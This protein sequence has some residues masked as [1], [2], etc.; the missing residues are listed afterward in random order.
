LRNQVALFV[1][2]LAFVLP[3]P[4]FQVLAQGQQASGKE[5]GKARQQKAIPK[6]PEDVHRSQP[7]APA[8]AMEARKKFVSD[9]VNAAVDLA[10]GDPQD[11]LRVLAAAANVMSSVS[12]E[13]AREFADEGVQLEIR[14]VASGKKPAV[15]IM[16]R[17]QMKCS[18]AQDFVEMLPVASVAAA[19][20]S[21]LGALS[22]CRRE[23]LEPVKRKLKDAMQSGVLAPRALLAAME[24]EGLKSPWSTEQFPALFQSL[25]R[26]AEKV[27]KEAPNFAA[28][29]ARVAPEIDATVAGEAGLHLLEW[30]GR[31]QQ[32]DER[33]LAVNITTGTLQNILGEEKYKELLG[34]NVMALQVAQT[35][36]Q[37]GEIGHEDEENVSVLKALD[38][39]GSDQSEILRE[40]P[41]SLRARE[42][43]AHGFAS[44]TGGDPEGAKK[45][46]DMAFS[47][48]NEVW[49]Q[50]EKQ[51]TAAEVVQEVSEA[52]A[53]VDTVAALRRVQGLSDPSAQ[54]IG[55]LAV[56]RVALS[57]QIDAPPPPQAREHHSGQQ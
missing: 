1:C 35:A 11:R 48:L 37:P 40:L 22:T 42:A 34:K 54:A 4:A 25:P 24:A 44:G 47:A 41:P 6:N 16:E 23:T 14:L 49:E 21:I 46:F 19:E 53:H 36:G 52:A 38:A 3:F 39:N 10:Q 28:M 55:M 20:Q 57:R 15:S 8:S 18:V 30:L 7:P 29:F 9:V 33:N 43:A 31:L 2:L 27:S 13:K 50:R 45:Y 17:G 51:N 56:A 12:P 32:G 26:D 5:T